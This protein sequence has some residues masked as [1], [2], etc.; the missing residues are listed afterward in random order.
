MWGVS[1]N[2]T[3]SQSRLWQNPWPSVEKNVQN[4]VNRFWTAARIQMRIISFW[5]CPEYL[6]PAAVFSNSKG[7]EAP[8]PCVAS[9][10][11][12]R[13]DLIEQSR[14]RGGPAA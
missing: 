4:E 8:T 5:G 11:A 1:R 7:G 10:L 2:P 12:T 13:L 9:S 6:S 14:V 3:C